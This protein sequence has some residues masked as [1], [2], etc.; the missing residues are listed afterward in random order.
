M[1]K[2]MMTYSKLNLADC[3]SLAQRQEIY[4]LTVDGQ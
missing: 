3:G 1:D 4:L 2:V